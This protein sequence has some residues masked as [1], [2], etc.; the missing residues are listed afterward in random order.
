MSPLV[1]HLPHASRTIP[2]DVRSSLLP[3]D[4]TIGRELL[5]LTDAW[6]DEIV[7]EFHPEAE[8]VIFPVSRLVVDPE[9]FPDDADEPMAA[10]GM[11]AG[12]CT[13]PEF[14]HGLQ[15]FRP[16]ENAEKI[17]DFSTCSSASSSRSRFS[18]AA[19]SQSC[20]GWASI[21]ITRSSANLAYSTP[22]YLP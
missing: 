1:L 4:Q 14:S 8:R 11:G 20:R 19:I 17:G 15:E 6:T 16:R 2:Q 13:V 3:D 5:L 12:S 21:K 10:R 7:A 9:R 22:V 18:T